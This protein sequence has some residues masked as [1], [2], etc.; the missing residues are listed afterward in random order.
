MQ[1]RL[2]KCF[3]YTTTYNLQKVQK[4]LTQ[5]KEQMM[6]AVTNKCDHPFRQSCSLPTDMQQDARSRH[7]DVRFRGPIMLFRTQKSHPP[8][9]R[10]TLRTRRTGP[11][12]ERADGSS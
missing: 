8:L 7:A 1:W 3:E 11:S 9:T 12:L 10:L 4:S 5:K 2:K 6:L